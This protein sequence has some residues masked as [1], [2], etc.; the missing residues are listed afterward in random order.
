MKSVLSH[1]VQK[2]FSGE[3]ENIAT[4]AL[5]YIVQTNDRARGGLL[6][7][8]R[9]IKPDLP[10]LSFQTQQS[11]NNK[12]PDMWGLDGGHPCLFIENKFWAGFTKNQPVEYIK[13]LTNH[14]K[15]GILLMVVPAAREESAWRELLT[16]L[17]EAGIAYN[18]QNPTADIP[19]IVCTD[20]GPFLALTSW[21]R[22]LQS[23]DN[24]LVDEPQARNDLL[25]LRALCDIAASDAFIPL[26]ASEITDQRIPA[27]V[28]QLYEVSQKA[29]EV[30]STQGFISRE[31]TAAASTSERIGRYL[32]FPLA[33]N[34]GAW[35]GISFPLWQK[36]GLSPLWL[37]F[38]NSE[39]SRANEVRAIAEPWAKAE[40]IFTATENN[41]YE[42]NI[43]I[44]VTTGEEI[45]VVVRDI[46]K[47][48]QAIGEKI[49]VLT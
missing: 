7:M 29:I 34:V 46:V 11:E 27:I 15:E 49:S 16:R 10:N 9:G 5:A 6:K 39:W 4:E 24:E 2:Q 38:T 14:N 41:D 12:R 20:I 36:Y 1:I 35:L 26:S 23:I 33:A 48:L 42:F 25:Q 32:K 17:K 21:T 47:Q 8:L 3:Y 37:I 19:R 30:A 28:A 13:L 31:G 45:D 22:L 44:K 43:N 40:N 18:D